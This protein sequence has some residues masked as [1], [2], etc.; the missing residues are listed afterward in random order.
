MWVIFY[1][2]A[3]AGFLII[4]GIIVGRNE[5]KNAKKDD[6]AALSD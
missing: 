3:T 5:E 1:I 4:W 2:F 6:K